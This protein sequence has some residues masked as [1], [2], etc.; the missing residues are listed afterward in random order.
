MFKSI[1]VAAY[2]WKVLLKSILVQILLVALV[3]A[4]GFTLFG[5]LVG[6]LIEVIN[7]NHIA[8]FVSQT[9]N[10]IIDGTFES[11]QFSERLNEVIT[12]WHDGIASLRHPFGMVSLTYV[13]FVL[14][15]LL[16]RLLVSLT[17]VTVACQLDEFMTSNAS[18]PFLWYFIK[19]QGRTWQF[20]LLQTALAL[21]LDVLILSGS[22]GFYLLFLIAFNWWTIIP[23]C[24]IALLMYT[25]R[26]TLLGF[27]LPSVVCKDMPTG[28]AF[29]EG[30]SFIFKRFWRLFWKTLIVVCLMVV[31]CVVSI[32]FVQNNLVVTILITIPNFVLFF[33][34]KCVN[35]VDYFQAANRPFF[36]KRVDIEGTDS[37]NRRHGRN[38]R[39]AENEQPNE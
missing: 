15:V 28:A 21:P 14:M 30:L 4:L 35:I 22:V 9:I 7:A 34:L 12:N 17:D 8:D 1:S 39:V 19:K 10:Q 29:T 3:L 11:A 26:L 25:V 36:Y 32:M 6:D 23:V 5:N 16:Y 18:R 37:Y 20:A 2:N 38:K 13:L 33:Y 27:C 24:V 31:I